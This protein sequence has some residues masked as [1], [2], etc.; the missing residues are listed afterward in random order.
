MVFDLLLCLSKTVHPL[1]SL[2]AV[3]DGTNASVFGERHP[4]TVAYGSY[5]ARVHSSGSCHKFIAREQ[6][7]VEKKQ[8][9]RRESMALLGKSTG[10]W[11]GRRRS[12]GA[13]DLTSEGD[14]EMMK[15]FGGRCRRSHFAI[16]RACELQLAT[17][18]AFQRPG[19]RDL[20][21]KLTHI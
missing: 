4:V 1:T 3:D 20:H 21:C 12:N 10:V 9:L 13:V 19:S 5:G 16:T 17:C 11:E 14:S 2:F 6:V 18:L 15:V 7:L 8:D